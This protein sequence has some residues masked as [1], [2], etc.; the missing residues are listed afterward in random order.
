MITFSLTPISE[1]LCGLQ[2]MQDQLSKL[3]EDHPETLDTTIP[4]EA[5]EKYKENFTIMLKGISQI[6][7]TAS[8][9]LIKQILSRLSDMSFMRLHENFIQL[10]EMLM[11][12]LR[13]V[14][15][16][17]I[18][19]DKS[20]W[21][22]IAKNVDAEYIKSFQSA[23][24]DLKEAAVCYACG[25]NTAAVFHAMRILECGLGALAKDVGLSFNV[26]QWGTI[27][28]QI[29][30]EIKTIQKTM[31]SGPAKNE[32]LQFLS[33]AAKEF[34]YFKDGWRN[35]VSHRRATYD[36]PKALSALNH[37][38]EFM[39]HLSTKLSE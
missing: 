7:L 21:L 3:M 39:L 15:L 27:I 24:D 16:I 1:H 8:S 35:Y 6:E 19:K 9:K 33:E 12:E 37:V 5:S 2:A 4:K 25:C 11:S 18:P 38:R 36:G 20:I 26:Q 22:E 23:L 14:L 28:D 31:P 32:R 10:R 17:F 30:K 13:E 29:E 34:A